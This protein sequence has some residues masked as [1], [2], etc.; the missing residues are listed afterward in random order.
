MKQIYQTHK[1]PHIIV[2]IGVMVILMLWHAGNASPQFHLLDMVIVLLII[3]FMRGKKF[4]EIDGNHLIIYGFFGKICWQSPISETQFVYQRI[5]FNHDEQ[6]YLILTHHE[7]SKKIR[8]NHCEFKGFGLLMALNQL[9]NSA[10]FSKMEQNLH[11]ESW[12]WKQTFRQPE[13]NV[14]E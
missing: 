7:Q 8:L 14:K 6:Y 2:W 12:S 1:F 5:R 10:F 4:A 9:A 11:T 3:H 13:K